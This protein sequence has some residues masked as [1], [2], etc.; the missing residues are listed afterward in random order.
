M[1][2]YREFAPTQFDVKGLG[3][4]ERADWL[5]APV[6]KTR[7]SGCLDRANF[8]ATLV[9]LGKTESVEVHRFG[10]WGPGWFEIILIDP[11]NTKAVAIAEDI[12]RGLADYPVVD[13]MLLSEYEWEEA[14]EVW[15]NMSIK[16][17]IDVCVKKG[18]SLKGLAKKGWPNCI[19]SGIYS[20]DLISDH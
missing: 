16:D 4:P 12:E 9:S 17:K 7:D 10:H 2:R 6:S 19:P 20:E 13:E 11:T 15:D 3:L 5:V 1:I 8:D 14:I 18:V